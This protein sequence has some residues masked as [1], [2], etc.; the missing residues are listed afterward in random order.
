MSICKGLPFKKL[1]ND[2]LISYIE[3]ALK[4]NK[5]QIES[6]L[7]YFIELWLNILTMKVCF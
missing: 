2:K 6:F 5:E 4:Q 7:S 1:K 3:N